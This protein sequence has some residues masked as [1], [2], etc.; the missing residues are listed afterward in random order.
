LKH[1]VPRHLVKTILG[2]FLLEQWGLPLRCSC[3]GATQEK[4]T[5]MHINNFQEM[6]I[7]ELQELENVEA[8]LEQSLG[9]LAQAA[10]NPALKEAFER[11]REQTTTHKERLQSI[12]QKHGSAKRAHTDQAMQGLVHETE[13]MSQMVEGE[14]LRDAALIASAQKIEHYEIAAYGTA[15]ALAAQLDLRD[16]EKMLHQ[17]LG[18]EKQADEL[19]TKL[20]KS[21]VNKNAANA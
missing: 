7:A 1:S 21:E 11:H 18:E 17:T 12:L 6:Y 10:S 19:L 13:K 3:G 14:G 5:S 15:A 9:R 20:A 8:Q 2:A 4:D 16:D